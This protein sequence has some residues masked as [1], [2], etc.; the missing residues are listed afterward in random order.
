MT[1]VTMVVAAMTVVAIA[2]TNNATRIASLAT[3]DLMVVAA[4][5]NASLV[6]YAS[7]TPASLPPLVLPDNM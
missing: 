1:V 5:V 7:E 2:T 6:G 3:V 4:P